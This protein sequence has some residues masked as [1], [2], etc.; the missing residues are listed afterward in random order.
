MVVLGCV[1]CQANSCSSFVQQVIQ[2][3]VM[4]VLFFVGHLW[5]VLMGGSG[6]HSCVRTYHEP[7][8]YLNIITF[9]L[10]PYMAFVFPTANGI[11]QQDNASYHEDQSW[12]GSGSILMNST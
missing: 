4:A 12:S 5:D 6:T 1:V 8:N 10:Q 7:A 11:F 9:Q 2:S 3:L